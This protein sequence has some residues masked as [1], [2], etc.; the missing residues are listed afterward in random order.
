MRTPS[1]ALALTLSACATRPTP[2][3]IR[4]A[5]VR[6]RPVSVGPTEVLVLEFQPGDEIPFDVRV[7]GPLVETVA[8]SEPLRLRAVRRFFLRVD[9]TGVATSLDG[10]TFG[11]HSAPG[12]FRV[13]VNVTQSA[14]VTAS[15]AIRTPTPR[16]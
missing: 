15:M 12:T 13:G 11:E 14:G 1:I 16:D 3:V 2:L 10:V 7:E 4:A 6:S 8:P 5:D 9:R